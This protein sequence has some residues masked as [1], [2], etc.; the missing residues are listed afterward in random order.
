MF[1]LYHPGHVLMIEECHRHCDHLT[2]AVNLASAFDDKIN[3]D[4]RLPFFTADERMMVLRS[5]RNVD[6]V[7]SYQSEAELT[8]IMEEGNFQVRF[9]GDDYRGKPITA[10]HAIPKIHY[11]D[12]SHGLSTSKYVQRI[13]DRLRNEGGQ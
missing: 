4:K 1:D 2:I 6:E 7:I 5:V 12:R 3:P 11:I 10:A 8:K 13:A 9:L